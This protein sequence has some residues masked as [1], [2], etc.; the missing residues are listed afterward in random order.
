MLV[1]PDTDIYTLEEI[2]DGRISE[3]AE[4]IRKEGFDFINETNFKYSLFGRVKNLYI[5]SEV[6]FPDE[7]L[8]SNFGVCRGY[9]GGGVHTAL[10]RTEIDRIS[11]EQ[12]A[13]ASRIL[14]AIEA[15]FWA[16]LK[17]TDKATEEHTGEKL[18]EWESVT[19]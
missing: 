2:V 4:T 11:E 5:Y 1:Q 8:P 17:D 3:L 14:D 12:H 19:I 10:Q 16:I 9:G 13:K 7:D 15:T 6:L 18:P